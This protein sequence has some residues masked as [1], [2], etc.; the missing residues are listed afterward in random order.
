LKILR[1]PDAKNPKIIHWTAIHW[2]TWSIH[3]LS[4][5]HRPS[6]SSFTTRSEQSTQSR[7]ANNH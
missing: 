2:D 6:Q 7:V 4:S 3:V 5:N 1:R